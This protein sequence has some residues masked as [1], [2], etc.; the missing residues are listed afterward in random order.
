MNIWIVN[1]YAI[2][3]TQPGI[4]RHF[5]L[6]AELTRQGHQVTIIASSFDH[7]TRKETRLKS[8]ELYSTEFIENVR[9]LWLRTPSYTGNTK[10]RIWNMLV[11]A[12]RLWRK[13]G[14]ASLP[15]PDVIVGSSPHLFGAFAAWRLA[16]SMSIPFVLEIRDLWPASLVELGNVSSSHPIVIGLGMIERTLYRNAEQI[17]TLLPG[18][19]PYIAE[20][21]GHRDKITWVPNGIHPKTIP[22]NPPTQHAAGKP[23]TAMYLGSHGL[24]NS[25]D[26]VL[27]AAK[28]LKAEGAA[29]KI[30]FRLIGDGPN[31][32]ALVERAAQENL[33]EMVQFE[34]PV[35][36]HV[37]SEL[38]GEADLLFITFHRCSLYRWGFST[39]KLFDY[40][41]AGRPIV[42]AVDSGFNPV[43]EADAGLTVP[44]GD[45]KAFADAIKTLCATSHEERWQMG[46]NGRRYVEKNH[47]MIQ[48]AE[49]F[50]TCLQKASLPATLDSPELGED[51]LP[52]SSIGQQL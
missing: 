17:V 51:G 19:P 16:R 12:W 37:V 20:R 18:T 29:D 13:C 27:D 4:I 11:F 46:L 22:L 52:D 43:A 45:A 44:P 48:L 35:P 15:K 49:R 5:N 9:F 7:L 31:K 40:F 21:G 39:N 30:R 28:L 36:K 2:L 41:A 32:Q 23:L 10:R 1:Q 3:P 26:V 42:I 8:G 34:D 38:V 6:A 33:G 50:E 47:D 14:V 24:A 25:L